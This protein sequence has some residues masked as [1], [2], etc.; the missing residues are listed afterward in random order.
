MTNTFYFEDGMD[1]LFDKHV[2]E[3]KE[4]NTL[5]DKSA[6]SAVYNTYTNKQRE[7]FIDKMIENPEEKGNIT[8]FSKELLINPRTAE[9]WWKTLAQRALSLRNMRT[10]LRIK[11]FQDFSTSKSQLNHHLRNIMQITVK[12]PH[13]EAEVRNSVDNLETRYEWFMNWKN[14]DLDYTENCVFI[15]EAGFHIN[16][17]NNWARSPAG[18]RAVV[19][20]AKTR[21]V[22]KKKRK[23]NSGK[24]RDVTQTN[25]DEGTQED[26]IS[27]VDVKPAPKGIITASFIKFVNELLDIMDKDE[28]L[29]GS[30]LVMDNT[31]IHKSKPMTRKIEA[32][33]YR[34]MYLTPYSPELNPIEQFWALVKGK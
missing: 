28:S 34:V 3:A 19:K 21:T 30:Y 32:R 33:G 29:K 11:Q 15:D 10:M 27:A 12:K 14:K 20:T 5:D 4:T 23:G 22:V 6:K 24:K 16:M 2:K 13:F 1:N 7:G 17:R 31:S 9:R 25:D 18:T 26:D 8:R